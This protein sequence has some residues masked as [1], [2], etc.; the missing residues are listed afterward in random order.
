MH[1]KCS[2]KSTILL[3]R[4]VKKNCIV[5]RFLPV[6]T[7]EFIS[8]GINSVFIMQICWLFKCKMRVCFLAHCCPAQRKQIRFIHEQSAVIIIIIKHVNF[9][10]KLYLK[11]VPANVISYKPAKIKKIAQN[12]LSQ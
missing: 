5:F 7:Y 2:H 1:L 12:S 11:L 6:H 9:Q 10:F 4:W 3:Q 8:S